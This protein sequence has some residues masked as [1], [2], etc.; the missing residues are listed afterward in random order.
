MLEW[1]GWLGRKAYLL[2]LQK[3]PGLVHYTHRAAHT[4]CSSSSRG[5]DTIFWPLLVLGTHVVHIHTCG[6]NT[7]THKNKY[8]LSD[9]KLT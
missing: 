3:D 4:I 5:S 1:E 7:Y 9:P 8:I 6:K 2:L